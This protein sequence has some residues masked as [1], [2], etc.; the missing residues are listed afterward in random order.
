MA[1]AANCKSSEGRKGHTLLDLSALCSLKP[2]THHVEKG[3]ELMPYIQIIFI[4]FNQVL[5]KTLLLKMNVMIAGLCYVST[6]DVM[7]YAFLG[8]KET[9]FLLSIY[10]F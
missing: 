9:S 7:S 4:V 5:L 8:H 1:L 3:Q 2:Y 6:L 10:R